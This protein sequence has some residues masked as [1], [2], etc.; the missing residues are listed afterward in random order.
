[1]DEE[2]Q[3]DSPGKRNLCWIDLIIVL[4]GIICLYILLNII[5]IGLFKVWPREQTVIY[6]NAFL[7]QF[8]FLVLILV[9]KKLRRWEWADFGWRAISGRSYFAKV[10][11][12]Y[13]LSLFINFSYALFLY[14]H[15]FTPPDTDVYARLLGQ[16][17]WYML[18]INLFLAG[19][20]APLAE[21]TIFRGIIFGSL[22]AHF[23]KWTAAALSSAVFAG[24]HL[25]LYGFFPRFMLG[26]FLVYLFDKYKSLY[27]A[28]ALHA[29]NN[30][31][32]TLLAAS[33]QI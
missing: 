18:I 9:L 19:F 22:Q 15:G 2:I 8:S 10:L 7:T 32:A 20:I 33:L 1:M 21:E 3:E 6:L 16:A 13:A 25:Q 14:Q 5:T 28:A 31:V 17:A 4:G 23:G 24:L 12:I 30:I 11:G 26:M 29:V 27:P